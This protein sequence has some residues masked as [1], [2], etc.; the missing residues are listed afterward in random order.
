M[1]CKSADAWDRDAH[2]EDEQLLEGDEETQT[3]FQTRG[4]WCRGAAVVVGAMILVFGMLALVNSARAITAAAELENAVTFSIATTAELEN[5]VTF[6]I[7]TTA[8]PE[9]AVTFGS[10]NY[11]DVKVTCL[12]TNEL[13]EDP[14]FPPHSKSTSII[15]IRP[16][17]IAS[18]PKFF[19]KGTNRLDVLQGPLMVGC[20][21][22]SLR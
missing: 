22:Q 8:E 20:W 19:V 5:A 10:H 16:Q 3:Y 4:R 14:D 1:V 6:S 18:N 11:A 7:A 21:R 15:W 2:Q 12:S 9:N 13:F 17:E